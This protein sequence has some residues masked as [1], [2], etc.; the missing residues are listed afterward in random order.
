MS[1]FAC[2]CFSLQFCIRRPK[3]ERKR[4]NLLKRPTTSESQT[5]NL[6]DAEILDG[7]TISGPQ[8]ATAPPA[9]RNGLDMYDVDTIELTQLTGLPTNPAI[10]M[11]F[12]MDDAVLPENVV[13]TSKYLSYQ[14]NAASVSSN[15]NNFVGPIGP[16]DGQI[17]Q[18]YLANPRADSA[19]PKSY[20]DY[21]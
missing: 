14:V 15:S 19:K 5:L 21:V 3:L 20:Y 1:L 4:R 17:D 12:S 16:K 13:P 10:A 9:Y 2:V 6:A 8:T 7:G 18:P 11:S